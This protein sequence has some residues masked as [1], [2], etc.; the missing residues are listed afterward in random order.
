MQVSSTRDFMNTRSTSVLDGGESLV[1]D[2][3]LKKGKNVLLC[4]IS[5]RAGGPPH[6]AKGMVAEVDIP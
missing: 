5:D 2:L 4:F 1:T 6:V 3:D